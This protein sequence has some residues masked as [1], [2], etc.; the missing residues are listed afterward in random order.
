[1]EETLAYEKEHGLLWEQVY[2]VMAKT[3][4][5]ITAFILENTADEWAK[6]PLSS[7]EGANDW[8]FK[9]EQWTSFRDDIHGIYDS[10]N[11]A[12]NIFGE[13]MNEMFGSDWE[14]LDK[15]TKSAL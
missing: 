4:E 3:P 13:S 9:T 15:E 2:E 8:I 12:W 11:A 7:T 6:S 1:M 5:E 14:N 10:L